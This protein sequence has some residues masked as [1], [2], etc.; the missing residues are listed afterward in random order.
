MKFTFGR[1]VFDEPSNGQ[2]EFVTGERSIIEAKIDLGECF[3][4]THSKYIDLLPDVYQ[5]VVDLYQEQGLALPQNLEVPIK[6]GLKRWLLSFADGLN[7]LLYTTIFGVK[8]R[9]DRSQKLRFLDNL[10]I[11]QFL[12]LMENGYGNDV[13]LFQTV[14]SPFEE[15]EPAFPGSMIKR[16]THVQILVRDRSCIEIVRFHHL[17]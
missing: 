16:Q 12:S 6:G 14:R 10:V 5:S 1:I 9:R 15:G 13:I 8:F 17:Y 11:N 7:A 3:D 4:L 2:K